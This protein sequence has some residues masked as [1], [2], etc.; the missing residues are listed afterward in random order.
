MERRAFGF[1]LVIIGTSVICSQSVSSVTGFVVNSGLSEA[2]SWLKMFGLGI[3]VGGVFLMSHKETLEKL[4]G[5][6]A[7]PMKEEIK[8]LVVGKKGKPS[9]E[10]KKIY[11]EIY[12]IVNGEYPGGRP[13]L[14][15]VTH[16]L[17]L[18]GTPIM[19]RDAHY[20]NDV[21]HYTGPGIYRHVFDKTEEHYLGIAKHVAKGEDLKW[22]Y[23]LTK[24]VKVKK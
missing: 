23:R 16:K 12:Q 13:H 20:L 14:S 7:E 22:V 1:G 15:R 2:F 3:I 5:A 17:G 8:E 10:R 6:D 4:L 19:T 24:P 21:M 18:N 9:E 11:D